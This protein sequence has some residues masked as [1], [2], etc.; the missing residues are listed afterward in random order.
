MSIV[1]EGRLRREKLIV[2]PL[3]TTVSLRPRSTSRLTYSCRSW[4]KWTKGRREGHYIR[5]FARAAPGSDRR[6]ERA[7]L[8]MKLKHK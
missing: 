4:T 6:N 3:R 7:R 2:A 1:N 5:F 8:V